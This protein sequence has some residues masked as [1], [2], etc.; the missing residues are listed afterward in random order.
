MRK[1]LDVYSC[2][3]PQTFG[4]ELYKSIT[5]NHSKTVFRPKE[6]DLITGDK[7]RQP[8]G[9][10]GN[11]LPED[12]NNSISNTEPETSVGTTAITSQTDEVI[13]PAW[14]YGVGAGGLVAV[15]TTAIVVG[16][17]IAKKKR[18]EK[19]IEVAKNYDYSGITPREII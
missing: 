18:K 8:R 4:E 11:N 19:A 13:I 5:S 12:N 15:T 10:N 1:T 3:T 14:A 17:G 2:N 7:N 9:G 16:H 6:R